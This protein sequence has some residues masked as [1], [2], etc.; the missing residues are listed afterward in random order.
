MKKKEPYQYWFTAAGIFVVCGGIHLLFDWIQYSNTFNSA[1]FSVWILANA[2]GFGG[3]AAVCAVV[4][5][6]LRK[7][8][9]NRGDDTL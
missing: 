1:P 8:R 2:I 9:K 6:I 7:K 5:W 4:G 3:A